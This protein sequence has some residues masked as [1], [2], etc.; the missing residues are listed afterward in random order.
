M[1]RRKFLKKS[2]GLLTAIA[3][4]SHL[5]AT[6]KAPQLQQIISGGRVLFQ[7]KLQSLNL[8]VDAS[9][10]LVIN[11]EIQ[12]GIPVID[13]NGKIV[14]PGFIDILADNAANPQQTFRTFEKYK[15]AQHLT[16]NF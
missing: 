12:E 8:G 16:Q 15:C 5:S 10:R 4:L 6:A 3:C 1:R 9:G 2:T 14:S 13:A 11:P 7:K